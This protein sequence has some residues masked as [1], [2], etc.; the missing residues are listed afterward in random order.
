MSIKKIADSVGVSAATV[1]RVLNNP[2]YHCSSP[3]LRDKIWN[4]AMKMNY[5]PNEAARN[6]RTKTGADEQ[7]TYSIH[8]LVT[9]TDSESTDPFFREL[10]HVVE[11][12]IHRQG[13]ILSKVWYRSLFSDDKRCKRE[14]IGA[15]IERMREETDGTGDGLIVIGKCNQ[16]A[17][18]KLQQ[19]YKS[20]VYVNRDSS[21]GEMD[22]VI[23]NGQKLA[24]RAVDYLIS[25]GHENIGYV[26]VR[27]NEARYRGYIDSLQANGLDIDTDYVIETRQTEKEGFEAMRRF[28]E[29]D[30]CPTGIYCSNDITAI[31]MLKYLHK[32]KNRYYMPS[33]ISS[34][35]IEEAQYTTP[36]LTTVQVSRE[37]MGKFAMYLLLDRLRGGHRGNVK[38]ELECKLMK[39]D[40]CTLAEESK[41]CDYYI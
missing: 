12:E 19:Y 2:D 14:D 39:R 27:H 4:T 10:L 5:V 40:S 36:M 23:C 21:Q 9:R 11:S 17:L 18:R 28:L 8:V 3:E 25:L 33:I 1:S 20:A 31:G 22:E 29:S 38:I 30:K 16:L 35:G 15:I 34:D 24:S 37:E 13:C 41:W 7:K 6:L 26:G 32:H